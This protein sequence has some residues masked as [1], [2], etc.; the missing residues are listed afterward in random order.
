MSEWTLTDALVCTSVIIITSKYNHFIGS[1]SS[2][3][4]QQWQLTL[5][6][7]L[8]SL[9]HCFPRSTGLIPSASPLL[10]EKTELCSERW[11]DYPRSV[12]RKEAKPKSEPKQIISCTT[13]WPVGDSTLES[14][15]FVPRS[16]CINLRR[17]TKFL[18][19][20]TWSNL[21]R[22]VSDSLCSKD[23]L[24]PLILLPLS[25][26]PSVCGSRDPTQGFSQARQ[27]F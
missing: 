16:L 10:S 11:N 1:T 5:T 8:L 22:N 20:W 3:P 18:L 21:C 27:A 9:R 2:T 23:D 12:T 25:S 4:P 26:S 24:G 15:E 14:H 19:F 6:G 13:W 17:T 7:C